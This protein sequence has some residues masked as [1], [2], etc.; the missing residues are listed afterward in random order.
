MSIASPAILSNFFE[1]QWTQN[2]PQYLSGLSRALCPTTFLKIAVLISSPSFHDYVEFPECGVNKQRRFFLLVNFHAALAIELQKT[3]PIFDKLSNLDRIN[4]GEVWQN[5][6]LSV[7]FSLPSPALFFETPSNLTS[8]MCKIDAFLLKTILG[9]DVKVR[10]FFV[11]NI[12][13]LS[14]LLERWLYQDNL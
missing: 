10:L 6:I 9:A 4:H 2:H 1:K 12:P 14:L 7:T 11:T 5:F 3:S 8:V 13:F